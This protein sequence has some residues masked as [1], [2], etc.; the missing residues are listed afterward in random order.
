M[1]GGI[2]H[3]LQVQRFREITHLRYSSIH[4]QFVVKEEDSID[5]QFRIIKQRE[6][7][8]SRL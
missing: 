2:E 5:L 3:P 1:F 7:N 8:L 6:I 4:V